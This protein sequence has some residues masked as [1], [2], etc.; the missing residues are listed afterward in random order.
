MELFFDGACPLCARE[1]ELVRKLDTEGE[2]VLID[3]AAPS[4]DP[5][6]YGRTLDWFESSMRSRVG[7]EWVSGVDTFREMWSRLG[8]RRAVSVSRWP[9]IS[10]TLGLSYALFA[11]IRPHLPGRQ[12]CDEACRVPAMDSRG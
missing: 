2:L 6:A 10:G 8:Y 12:A 5:A 3:I 1:I 4:F 9:V 11:K 7:G